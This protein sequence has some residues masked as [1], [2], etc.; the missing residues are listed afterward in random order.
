MMTDAELRPYLG[1]RV[2]VHFTNGD[3]ISG[4]LVVGEAHLVHNQPYAI[5]IPGRSPGESPSWF[6]VP[7]ASA[8]ATILVLDEDEV[9][10]E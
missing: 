2:S 8:V 4:R 10:N 7:H 3:V 9:T 5:E 6:G 1:R